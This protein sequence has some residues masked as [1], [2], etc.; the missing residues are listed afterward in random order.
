MTP[1]MSSRS[2]SDGRDSR[3]NKL[4]D[5]MF[6]LSSAQTE[7]AVIVLPWSVARFIAWRS[8]NLSSHEEIDR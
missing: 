8:E 2:G 6:G 7:R 5:P 1:V 3:A 4:R